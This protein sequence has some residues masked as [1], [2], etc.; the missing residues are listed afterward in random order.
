MVN[1]TDKPYVLATHQTGP[2]VPVE[3]VS[4]AQQTTD[5]DMMALAQEASLA[6]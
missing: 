5:L 3:Q 4:V 1:D 2:A 6:Y